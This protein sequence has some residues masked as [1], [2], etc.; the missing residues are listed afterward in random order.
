MSK[1][2][3][4]TEVECIPGGPAEVVGVFPESQAVILRLE[5]EREVMVPRDEV[6]H[7]VVKLR[8]SRQGLFIV[9]K[10]GHHGGGALCEVRD[11]DL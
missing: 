6:S 2:W 11:C 3:M 4:G 1:L 10:R 9:G 5:S 7:G 8:L